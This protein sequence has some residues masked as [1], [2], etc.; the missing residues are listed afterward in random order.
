VAGGIWLAQGG[1]IL[2]GVLGTIVW[3]VWLMAREQGMVASCCD[4]WIL[5]PPGLVGYLLVRGIGMPHV[6]GKVRSTL[7]LGIVST[8]LGGL[9]SAGSGVI[10]AY[11]IFR[12]MTG[13]GQ[14]IG[15]WLGLGAAFVVGVS[16]LVSGLLLLRSRTAY[17]EYK[18]GARSGG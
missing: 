1:L 16:W 7:P 6:L 17:Q 5:I 13:A 11:A 4:S 2:L 15:L 18:L 3:Q 10:G 8:A 12:T 14:P 9:V